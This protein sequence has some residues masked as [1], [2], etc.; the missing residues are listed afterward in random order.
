MLKESMYTGQHVYRSACIHVE[1]F[2]GHVRDWN[3]YLWPINMAKVLSYCKH[4]YVPYRIKRIFI[5]LIYCIN[6][7]QD[8]N[9]CVSPIDIRMTKNDFCV[10]IM[11]YH[12]MD[13]L[14][15]I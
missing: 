9:Y 8:S 14:I 15:I 7:K 3:I 4:N 13:H 6:N 11:M 10:F 12:K 5:C 2:I 1:Q